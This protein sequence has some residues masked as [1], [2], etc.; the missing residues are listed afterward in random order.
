MGIVLQETLVDLLVTV[1]IQYA[2]VGGVRLAYETPHV[3]VGERL[4]DRSPA[5][6]GDGVERG[7]GGVP[8]DEGVQGFGV[9]GGVL[10]R[11]RGHRG[12]TGV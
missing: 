4:E 6:R 11:H 9:V 8:G 2:I 12:Q 10:G 1:G 3:V 7:D 5:L